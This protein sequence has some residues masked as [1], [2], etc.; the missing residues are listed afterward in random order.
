MRRT[1][2]VVMAMAALAIAG[3]TAAAQ[4][5]NFAGGWTV[6]LDPAAPA[7]P[8]GGRGGGRGLGQAATIAQDDKTLTVTR[9]TQAGE[10]KSVY[11][12]DGSESKNTLSMGGNSVDQV[13]T[14]KWDGAKLVITTSANFNG[15]AFTTTMAMWMDEAG[16]LAVETTSPGRG[17]GAPTT[18]KMSYK[19]G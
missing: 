6:I 17:G 1:S 5:K 11:N 8:A 16:N 13:S 4:G 18:T 3:S 14:A 19:K 15:N 9:T 12:L 7:P 2:V 10:I